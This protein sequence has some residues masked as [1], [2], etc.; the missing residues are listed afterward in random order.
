MLPDSSDQLQTVEMQML[1]DSSDQMPGRHINV[2]H[3]RIA[4]KLV[5]NLIFKNKLLLL[6]DRDNRSFASGNKNG[7]ACINSKRFGAPHCSFL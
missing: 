7:M 3:V 6:A 2:C 5:F 1:L 4:R